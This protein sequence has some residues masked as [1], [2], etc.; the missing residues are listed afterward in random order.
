ME[1]WGSI[2]P[3]P[4]GSWDDS[5]TYLATAESKKP[6]GL[7]IGQFSEEDNQILNEGEEF[8]FSRDVPTVRYIR[9]KVLETWAGGKN[10]FAIMEVSF[11]GGEQK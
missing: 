2:D 8:S 5:W 6:S 9:F 3:N 4:D 7:P 11:W 10:E 1:V